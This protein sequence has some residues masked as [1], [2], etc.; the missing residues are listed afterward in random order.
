MHCRKKFSRLVQSEGKRRKRGACFFFSFFLF[1]LWSLWCK[2]TRWPE[3]LTSLHPGRQSRL[4]AI[5]VK[6]H[7]KLVVLPRGK[8]SPFPF[9]LQCIW[10]HSRANISGS[11]LQ[12]ESI[13]APAVSRGM[14]LY[15][16]SSGCRALILFAF[17]SQSIVLLNDYFCGFIYR[18]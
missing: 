1:L 8:A 9:L 12:N 4:F 13:G 6:C 5:D 14:H 16:S 3:R 7:L 11:L 10:F 18:I 15:T 2:Q 17:Q